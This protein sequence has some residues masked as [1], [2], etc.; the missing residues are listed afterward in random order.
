MLL[1]PMQEELNQSQARILQLCGGLSAGQ[2][3]A[4]ATPEQWSIAEI[5]EHLTLVE[6]GAAAGIHRMLSQPAA[7]AEELAATGPRSEIIHTRVAKAEQPVQAPDV[8]SPTGRYGPWPSPLE[9]FVQIR[10]KMIALAEPDERHE[11]RT[12]PHP[13]IGPLTLTQWFEF[14]SA[15][16]NRH[17]AQIEAALAQQ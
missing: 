10:R 4:K 13:V 2:A 14:V 11:S 9:A 5:L 6:R 3:E 15:H 8:V 7:D 1:L 17:I 16:T 12:F